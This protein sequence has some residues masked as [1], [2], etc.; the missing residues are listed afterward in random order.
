MK[1]Q[2]PSSADLLKELTRVHI[3]EE[4]L[5]Y[6]DL[7]AVHNK[8]DCWEFELHEKQELIP[9]ELEGQEVMLDGFCN[10]VSILNHSWAL[11]KIYLIVK[12]RR[13]KQKGSDTHYSNSYE[14]HP[15][16]VKM[17]KEMAAFFKSIRLSCV[18]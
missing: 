13:W 16:S 7:H 11:K 6:F 9:K 18:R 15:Q 17:T 4:Y 8:P 14:L 1:T 12:R 3:A 2:A 10:P 5:K